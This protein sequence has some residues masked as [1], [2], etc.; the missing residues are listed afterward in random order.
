MHEVA[1]VQ[2]LLRQIAAL[3]ADHSGL[4]ITEVRLR[5]GPLSGVEPGQLQAAFELLAPRQ[6]LDSAT[7]TLNWTPLTAHCEDCQLDYEIVDF[8]FVCPTC[9]SRESRPVAGDSIVLESITLAAAHE[10]A[11]ASPS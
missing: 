6:G 3:A 2:T 7:L 8:S 4:R 5:V 9:G 1:L 10:V 11:A